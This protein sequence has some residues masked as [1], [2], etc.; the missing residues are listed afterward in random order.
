MSPESDSSA[1]SEAPS[2]APAAQSAATP[3]PAAGEATASDVAHGA[4]ET[5]RDVATGVPAAVAADSPAANSTHA[6]ELSPAAC[7][8]RLAELFPALFAPTGPVKPI[9]LR[10]HADIQARASGLFSKRTLGIFFSRHTSTNAYLKA[11]TL[12]PQRF[13]LDGQ[14]AGEISDEHRRL[15]AEELARRHALAA[16][17]RAAQRPP[18]REA[19]GAQGAADADAGRELR[20]E[21]RPDLRPETQPRADQRPAA[22]TAQ[23]PQGDRQRAERPEPRERLERAPQLQRAAPAAPLPIDPAQR[24]RA[25]L[26]RTYESSPLSKANFCALK[27]MTEA[28]FDAALAQ[29]QAERGAMPSAAA[30]RG[31]GR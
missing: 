23:R 24:E 19:P 28:A 8:M 3:T 9:K 25:M 15:A 26:L 21:H 7:G 20:Q 29:A 17:R 31:G 10:I 6:A 4:S 22:H 30:Q 13:D 12:A 16:S 5:L 2:A 27:G 1:A 11:L 14:P 18:R